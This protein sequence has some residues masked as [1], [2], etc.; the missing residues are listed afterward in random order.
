MHGRKAALIR[1][2]LA[3]AFLCLALP[4]AAQKDAAERV[5]EGAV[6]QWIEYYRT[7]RPANAPAAP[8][9]T[10]V[11]EMEKVKAESKNRVEAERTRK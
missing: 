4:V 9:G 1:G 3:L 6:D 10:S 2:A 11:D 8:A 5:Q 7:Q